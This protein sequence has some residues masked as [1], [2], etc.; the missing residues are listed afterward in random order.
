MKN[1]KIKLPRVLTNLNICQFIIISPNLSFVSIT[2][3]HLSV[4]QGCF[5]IFVHYKSRYCTG[6][7]LSNEPD[8]FNLQLL[9]QTGRP[10]PLFTI[11]LQN[12]MYFHQLIT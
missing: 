6:R 8:V 10:P 3:N 1:K 12:A 7:L 2:E 4:K 11:F 5:I 9:K